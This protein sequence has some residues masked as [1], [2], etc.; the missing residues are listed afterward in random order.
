M[1]IDKLLLASIALL[2]ACAAGPQRGFTDATEQD[3][4]ALQRHLEQRAAGLSAPAS[5]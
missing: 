2:S 3:R 1:T 4:D 5:A